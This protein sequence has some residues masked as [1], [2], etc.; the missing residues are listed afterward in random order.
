MA[1]PE[2]KLAVSAVFLGVAYLSR[3]RASARL[4]FALVSA[5]GLS[6]YFL[7]L[8]GLLLFVHIPAEGYVAAGVGFFAGAACG[9]VVGVVVARAALRSRAGYWALLI[10]AGLGFGLLP[11]M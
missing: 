5:M 8:A 7:S 2:L 10:L 6:M 9:A 3:R 1:S 11:K 4:L